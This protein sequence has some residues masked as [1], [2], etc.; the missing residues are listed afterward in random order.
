MVKLWISLNYKSRV[1]WSLAI[2]MMYVLLLLA[3]YLVHGG[4]L[5]ELCWHAAFAS[6]DVLLHPFLLIP[7]V[8]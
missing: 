3:L 1:K 7:C 5:C 8:T 4:A 2:F 6:A